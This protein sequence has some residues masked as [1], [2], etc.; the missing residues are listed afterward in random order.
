MRKKILST[1][2]ITLISTI[3]ILL[4]FSSCRTQHQTK[5]GPPPERDIEQPM[6]KYGVPVPH[7]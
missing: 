5:Y 2:Y 1:I 7:N 6:T 3:L 4:G